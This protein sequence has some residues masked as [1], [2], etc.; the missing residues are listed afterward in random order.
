M[1]KAA[2]DLLLREQRATAAA[3]LAVRTALAKE[4]ADKAK[5]AAEAEMAAKAAKT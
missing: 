4:K 1:M 5:A 3:E 2:K